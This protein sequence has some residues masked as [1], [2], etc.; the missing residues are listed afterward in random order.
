MKTV[1]PTELRA[2]VY[3]LLDEVLQ[4]GLPIEIK[5]GDKR[6]RI[7]PAE[8]ADKFM[9]LVARPHVI[10]GNPEELASLGWQDEVSLD[11]P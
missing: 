4:S 9:N 5:K 3:N 6:L 2:N 10:Q 1:T 8:K 11:L 7:V